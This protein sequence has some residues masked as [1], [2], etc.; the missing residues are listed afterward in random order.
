MVSLTEMVVGWS[1]VIAAR[2]RLAL[3]LNPF[4]TPLNELKVVQFVPAARL[5]PLLQHP[6]SK[7]QGESQHR[8]R[9]VSVLNA[10]CTQ[11]R[12]QR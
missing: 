9:L 3:T 6:H 8:L 5:P 12:R 2:L 7:R 11:T 4:H 10:S 1:C